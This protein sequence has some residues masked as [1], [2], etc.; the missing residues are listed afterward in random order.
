MTFE[1]S[2]LSDAPAEVIEAYTGLRG[3]MRAFALALPTAKSQVEA[4]MQAGYAEKTAKANASQFAADPAVRTVYEYLVSDALQRSGIT[5]E[6]CYRELAKIAFGDP[7]SLFGESGE[8]LPPD[9][10]PAASAAIVA[11]VQQIDMYEGVGPAREKVGVTN[12]IK[13]ADKHAALRTAMQLLAAFPEKRKEITHK[14]RIGVV[15]VPA[16]EGMGAGIGG[17]VID[18]GAVPLEQ[19]PRKGNAPQMMLR[20][21][22]QPR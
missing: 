20:R 19:P 18:V 12:K 8:L 5:L 6:R 22:P 2:P 1:T 4:A 9:K 14:H 13:F 10:W 16:K 7:K 17:E 21:I 3:K 11:E 15:V